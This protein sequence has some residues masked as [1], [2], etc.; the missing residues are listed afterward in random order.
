MVDPIKP[1]LPWWEY[2]IASGIG[3]GA[4]AYGYWFLSAMERNPGVYRVPSVIALLYPWGGK[5]LCVIPFAA[6]G[7][8]F[9]VVSVRSWRRKRTPR[10]GLDA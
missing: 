7:A 6:M 8:V 10:N 3:F 1:R 4:A 5:W 2:A 9:A